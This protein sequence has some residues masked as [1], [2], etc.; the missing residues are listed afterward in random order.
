MTTFKGYLGYRLKK[1]LLST[2][3]FSLLALAITS[4]YARIGAVTFVGRRGYTGIESLATIV[5]IIAS[6]IP[7]SEL[8]GFK[9]RRN[10]DTLFFLPLSRF[11]MALAHYISGFLQM[12]TIY[13]VAFIGHWL[14]LLQFSHYYRLEYMP[15]YY[16]LLLFLGAVVYSVFMFIFG[17]ANSGIDGVICAAVWSFALYLLMTAIAYPIRVLA[18]ELIY[19]GMDNV[20]YFEF[21]RRL[22]G[23]NE[24]FLPHAPINNLTVVFQSVMRGWDNF[25][26]LELEHYFPTFKEAIARNYPHWYMVFAWIAAGAASIWG[27]FRTFTRKGAERAGD[28]SDSPFCYKSLIPICGASMVVLTSEGDGMMFFLSVSAMYIGYAIYRKS[29]RIKKSDVIT[30]AAVTLGSLALLV[31]LNLALFH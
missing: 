5:G 27:Y 3:T 23:F 8:G 22:S 19:G 20:K 29:F 2:V 24:W 28:I 11:K 21:T 25:N 18:T 14:C 9:N 10:L 15:L 4:F 31:F 30:I 26:G 12:F 7:M 16:F 6:L 17:E 13:T 1:T